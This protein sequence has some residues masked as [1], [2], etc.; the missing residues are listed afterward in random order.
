MPFVVDI[1]EVLF[2]CFCV[3]VSDDTNGKFMV[4]ETKT[5]PIEGNG[6]SH[7]SVHSVLNQ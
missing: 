5:S 3:I 1:S 6:N 2:E 7:E 4:V